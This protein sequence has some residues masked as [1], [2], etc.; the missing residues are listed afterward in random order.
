[1]CS[2]SKMY[3]KI[4]SRAVRSMAVRESYRA[5]AQALQ[6]KIRCGNFRFCT[7]PSS[8]TPSGNFRLNLLSQKC[9][10]VAVVIVFLVLISMSHIYLDYIL[11]MII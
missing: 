4:K 10:P 6:G 5:A 1:M 11:Q 2:V 7:G 9:V 8:G 3:L